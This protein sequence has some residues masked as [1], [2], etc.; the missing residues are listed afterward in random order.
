MA[1]ETRKE[2]VKFARFGIVNVGTSAT[3]ITA[4]TMPDGD[5]FKGILLKA[6]GSSDDTPNTASVFIGHANITADQA[7]TGGFPL[8]PGESLTLPIDQTSGLYAIA[9]DTSQKL[10]WAII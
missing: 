1:F 5:V 6:P 3:Q 8:A 9:T 2:T 4:V 10:N 7:S